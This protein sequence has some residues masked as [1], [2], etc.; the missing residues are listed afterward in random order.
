[1]AI[2]QNMPIWWIVIL[3]IYIGTCLISRVIFYFVVY[4]TGF[5]ISKTFKVKCHNHL[6]CMLAFIAYGL[7]KLRTYDSN[8]VVHIVYRVKSFSC[9]VTCCLTFDS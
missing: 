2:R 7:Y 4:I 5:K 6:V 8:V 1:M 3:A 9:I